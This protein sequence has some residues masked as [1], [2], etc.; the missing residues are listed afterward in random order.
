MSNLMIIDDNNCAGLTPDHSYKMVHKFESILQ[1]I[2]R[3]LIP[4]NTGVPFPVTFEEDFKT[5]KDDSLFDLRPQL[6]SIY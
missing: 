2:E 1:D 4:T 6:N 3:G 5:D